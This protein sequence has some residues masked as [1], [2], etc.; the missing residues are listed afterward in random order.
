MRLFAIAA[1][2]MLLA[3]APGSAMAQSMFEQC[4]RQKTT[5]MTLEKQSQQLDL[6]TNLVNNQLMELQRQENELRQK[7]RLQTTQKIELQKKIRME[8]SERERLC[9]VIL[10]CEKHER[11]ADAL[12][13]RIAPQEDLLRR[14]RSD[15]QSRNVDSNRLSGEVDR[16]SGKYQSLN[17]DNLVPG[18]TQQAIIDACSDLFSQWNKLQ[19]E[20][21]QLDSSIG[22]LQSSY[23]KVMQDMQSTKAELD[24]LLADMH[25]TCSHSSRVGELE[26]I[27]REQGGYDSMKDDFAR[28]LSNVKRFR[29][30]RVLK[31]AMK[32]AQEQKQKPRLRVVR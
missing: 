3:G 9:S 8:T 13:Q 12:K 22:S 4:E 7:Q 23:Q 5:V 15:I 16:I 27:Q 17:C 24:R 30:V 2:A 32:P 10:Q 14:I 21:N 1:G 28:I 11:T 19:A 20:I 29:E 31:P 18:Q 25:A 6:D 26:S